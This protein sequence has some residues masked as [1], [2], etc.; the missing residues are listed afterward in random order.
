[1]VLDPGDVVTTGTPPGVGSARN[2]REYLKAGD[3]MRLEVERL[4]RQRQMV[5][6]F[7]M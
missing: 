5:V 6:P 4:G 2:P 3:M 7:K 1:M